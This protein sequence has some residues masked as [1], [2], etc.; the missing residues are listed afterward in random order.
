M[1]ELPA[2]RHRA[3]TAG[4]SAGSAGIFNI[5]NIAIAPYMLST[6][7]WNWGGKSF[8]LYTGLGFVAAFGS[9]FIIPEPAGRTQAELDEMFEAKVK[10]WRFRKYKTATQMAVEAQ[11]RA[12]G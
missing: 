10:P 6:T 1:G 11:H 8:F 3:H 4:F 7:S 5:T 12:Q 9:W 2:Q